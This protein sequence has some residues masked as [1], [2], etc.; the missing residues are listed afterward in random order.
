MN[1]NMNLYERFSAEYV[2]SALFAGMS[3]DDIINL[4]ACLRPNIAKYRKNDLIVTAGEKLESIGMLLTG[5]ASVSKE[6]AAGNRVVMV[7]LAPGDIFGE[8]VAFAGGPRW[9]ATVQAQTACA[10]MFI[11]KAQII[12]ECEKMCAWH[13]ELIQNMLKIISSRAMLLNKKVEYLAMKSM[14][15][16]LAAFLLE[17]YKKKGTLTFTL[18][19]KRH[20]MADFLNVSRPSMSRELGRMRDEGLIDYHLV[21]V[22]VKD[23]P[24]LRRILV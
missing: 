17:E 3:H 7:L 24:G 9:L 13:R 11:P 15:G 12:G 8:I 18:P 2:K 6:D 20:E 16:K 19:M 1:E 5:E 21:T 4:L 10:V 14:R 23:L 22:T